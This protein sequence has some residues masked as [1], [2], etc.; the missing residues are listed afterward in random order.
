MGIT[1]FKNVSG[2]EAIYMGEKGSEVQLFPVPLLETDGTTTA[3]LNSG[4]NLIAGGTGIADLT[5]A[6]PAPGSRVIIRIASISSGTVVVTTA[7]GV[8][9]DGTNNT[10]TFNAAEDTLELIYKSATEYAI[11][12][13][14]GSV[15]LS[16]V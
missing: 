14:Q 7:S 13:N 4:V 11:A 16:S 6:A 15:A 5:L 8:T 10:A 1:H 9:F 12:L 2:K 3:L